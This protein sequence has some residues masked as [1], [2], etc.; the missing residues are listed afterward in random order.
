MVFSSLQLILPCPA[1]AVTLL[2]TPRPDTGDSLGGATQ[3]GK[4]Q[5]DSLGQPVTEGSRVSWEMQVRGLGESKSL[6]LETGLK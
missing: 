5:A 3:R 4:L 2:A 1:P 6:T